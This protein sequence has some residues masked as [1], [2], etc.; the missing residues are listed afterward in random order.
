MTD[1]MDFIAGNDDPH[2]I[3]V[4]RSADNPLSLGEDDL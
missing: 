2:I 1:T 4:M 3:E